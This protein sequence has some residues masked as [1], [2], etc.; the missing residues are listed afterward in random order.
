LNL[1]EQFVAAR[2]A[3][4]NF[5]VQRNGWPDFFCEREDGRRIAIEVK[6]GSDSLSLAQRDM[7]AMFERAGIEVYVV[8]VEAPDVLHRDGAFYSWAEVTA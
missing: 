6:A 4:E 1:N 5:H 7:H 8:R 2:L 3:S